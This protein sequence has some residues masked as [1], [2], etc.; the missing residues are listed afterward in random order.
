MEVAATQFP[1]M[2]HIVYIPAA[3]LIGIVMGFV[4]GRSSVETDG[5]KKPLYDDDLDDY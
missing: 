1:F 3:V 5:E 2:T 4:I